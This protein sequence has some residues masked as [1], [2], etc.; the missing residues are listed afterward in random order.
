MGSTISLNITD[1]L[2]YNNIN[3]REL[4]IKNVSLERKYINGNNVFF[5]VKILYEEIF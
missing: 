2:R 4:P 5:R 3:A 1:I